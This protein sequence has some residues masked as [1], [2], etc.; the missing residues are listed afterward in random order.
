VGAYL[1]SS[2]ACIVAL[3]VACPAAAQAPP[4][5]LPPGTEAKPATPAAPAAPTPPPAA[6]TT[7]AAPGTTAAA[8][9][10]TAIEPVE[11]ERPAPP[12][13]QSRPP[14][15]NVDYLQYGVALTAEFAMTPGAS[16]PDESPGTDVKPCIIGSGGGLTLR[17]G[18]RSPGPWY[19]GGAYEFIKM[20]SGNLY[21][22]G[23]FQQLRAEMRY[24]PDFAYRVQPYVT[25][26]VGAVAY[27]NEWGV[28]TGGAMAFLG[29][30][31][32]IEVSRVAVFGFAFVYRPVLIFGWT[33]TAGQARDTGVAQFIGI[34]AIF[35][36]RTELGRR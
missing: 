12:L 29:G 23:I 36:L 2:T 7:D 25:W 6:G 8:P 24:L 16:C 32:E 27:G 33:D 11:P 30:G 19:F 31:I 1:R 3:L 4:P 17:G 35:E 5:Q 13:I 15:L 28:E 18:Y 10:N 22:L 20:D 9:T 21:R 14:P 26:G 34:E